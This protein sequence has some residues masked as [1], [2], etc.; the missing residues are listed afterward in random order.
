[1]MLIYAL[2]PSSIIMTSITLREPYQ[3]LLVNLGVFAALKIYWNKSL[4]H[5]LTMFFS[6]YFMSFLHGGLLVF[7]LFI[8]ISTLILLAR[9]RYASGF[10][11]I[12]LVFLAPIFFLIVIMGGEAFINS[13][14]NYGD[15]REGLAVGIESYQKG[16][17][18]A[19]FNSSASYR[20][21]IKIKNNFDLIL[22]IPTSLFQYLFEPMPWRA[23]RPQDIALL[24]ENLLRAY[25]I[26]KGWTG[27]R[28]AS[29]KMKNAMLFIFISYFAIEVIW[30]QGTMNWGLLP[31]IIFPG[32]AF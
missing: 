27:L 1:M 25:L 8:F 31:D 24:L 11:K 29:G 14:I 15:L 2:L 23:G 30:A 18:Q 4:M 13:S 7:G 26:W 22:F 19:N 21:T 9:R 10:N 16:G 5:W 20:D 32:W 3:L 28:R 6:V 12:K 17:I